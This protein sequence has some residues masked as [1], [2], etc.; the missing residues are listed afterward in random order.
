MAKPLSKLNVTRHINGDLEIRRNYNLQA[1][2]FSGNLALISINGSFY[3]DDHPQLSSCAGLYNLSKIGEH[4]VIL[5]NPQLE[6]LHDSFNS[7]RTVGGNLFI[8]GNM[9][10][11]NGLEALQEIRGSLYLHSLPFLFSL[12]GLS[13]LR[14]IGQDMFIYLN[15]QLSSISDLSQLEF[16]GGDVQIHDNLNLTNISGVLEALHH[17]Q[18]KHGCCSFLQTSYYL[19][20]EGYFLIDYAHGRIDCPK[21]SK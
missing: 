15:E 21:G 17:V 10:T 19:K 13:R 18:G 3:L 12:Q 7:L 16:V 14:T 20:I 1:L 8:Q 11:M 6:S 2:S 5:H 9:A 4:V